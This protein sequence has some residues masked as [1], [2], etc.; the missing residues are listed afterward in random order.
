M[1]T[2]KQTNKKKNSSSGSNLVV[3]P[4]QS[5]KHPN[6][7]KQAPKEKAKTEDT[8]KEKQTKKEDLHLKAIVC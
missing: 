5:I 3:T 6:N 7:K 4:D 8:N 2:N 1:K